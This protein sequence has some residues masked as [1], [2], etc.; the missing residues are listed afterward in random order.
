M[1]LVHSTVVSVR[2]CAPRVCSLESPMISSVDIAGYLR[3][4]NIFF[5]TSVL[6]AHKKIINIS[7][8]LFLIICSNFNYNSISPNSYEKRLVT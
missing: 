2:R 1:T 8:Y 6:I 3:H 7:F 5:I 4:R